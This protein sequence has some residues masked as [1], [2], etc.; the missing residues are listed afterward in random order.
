MRAGVQFKLRD[1]PQHEPQLGADADHL[2][3][4]EGRGGDTGGVPHLRR[5]DVRLVELPR[6]SVWAGGVGVLRQN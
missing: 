1:L 2:R 3:E 6:D 5:G 4:S